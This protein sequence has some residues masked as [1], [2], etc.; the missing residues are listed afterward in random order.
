MSL[1][2]EGSKKGRFQVLFQA[3]VEL[4]YNFII[5]STLWYLIWCS[6]LLR[7]N[8]PL[9]RV[10]LVYIVLTLE[11]QCSSP[12]PGQESFLILKSSRY[13]RFLIWK[14]TVRVLRNAWPT[15]LSIGAASTS[16]TISTKSLGKMPSCPSGPL[17]L[18]Q[19]SSTA[20]TKETNVNTFYHTRDADQ[21][22]CT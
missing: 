21:K 11:T 3:E 2:S 14:C 6:L 18:Y 17:P 13:S 20:R 7:P 1:G 10:I 22:L 4:K 16:R 19:S 8:A 15:Y 9:S 5:R 12:P